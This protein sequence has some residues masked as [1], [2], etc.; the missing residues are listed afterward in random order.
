MPGSPTVQTPRNV[1]IFQLQSALDQLRQASDHEQS[2]CLLKVVQSI[3]DWQTQCNDMRPPRVE[4]AGTI[5]QRS[6]ENSNAVRLAAKT[7]NK[8][9]TPLIE[10]LSR[11]PLVS[12]QMDTLFATAQAAKTPLANLSGHD[13]AVALQAMT[14]ALHENRDD[15]LSANAQDVANAQSQGVTPAVLDRLTLNGP[16]LDAMI[17]SIGQI[18]GQTDPVNRVLEAWDN[19]KNDLHFKKVSVPLGVIGIIYE[20]RPNV[21]T[22]AAAICLKSGNPVILRPGSNCHATS[23]AL[24]R[25]LQKGAAASGVPEGA[26]QIV[27]IKDREAVGEMLRARGKLDLIIPRGGASLTR[28]VFEEARVPT[29]LHLDGNC[30]T[31]VDKD[32]NPDT[33][34]R[35]VINAKMRRTGICGATE[36]LL[37]HQDVAATMLPDLAAALHG[38]NCE[39][40]G[41][42]RTCKILPGVVQRAESND[43][44]T[45]FLGPKIS[46]QVVDSL[47]EAIEVINENSSKH[48][49]SI[50][51]TNRLAQERFLLEVKSAITMV[52][53]S[54]QF[55]DGGEFGFGAEIGISTG[56]TPPRGPVGADQLVS[57]KYNV[58][59]NGAIRGG[60]SDTLDLHAFRLAMSKLLEN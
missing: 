3:V 40:V 13:K 4:G 32:A 23:T 50:I 24:A 46:I 57:F 53:T 41:D 9:L 42:D 2:D 10:N 44:K 6:S 39:M 35:V 45:E 34:I 36:S 59:S 29:L 60:G 16:R 22:D 56:Q 49:E 30:H 17:D 21:T 58:Y 38:N 37:V 51:S 48:T 1:L 55:A 7:L 18:A 12:A 28:R 15:I 14:K 47:E 33:A 26:I 8:N 31:Y 11:D 52:N 27:P 19:P 43:F 5:D 25:A 54:T 20:A